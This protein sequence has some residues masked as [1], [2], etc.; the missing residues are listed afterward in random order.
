MYHLACDLSMRRRATSE[1]SSRWWA[2]QGEESG[3]G[4]LR[5]AEDR[6]GESWIPCRAPRALAF[7][8][9][10][11]A[12][13][14]FWRARQDGQSWQQER[15]RTAD[16]RRRACAS[17]LGALPGEWLVIDHGTSQAQLGRGQH[18]QPGPA[19]S[20]FGVTHARE[21]P[22]ERLLQEAEGVLPGEQIEAADVGAPRPIQVGDL[23]IAWA[24]PPEPARWWRAGLLGLSGKRLTSPSSRV[25]RTSGRRPRASRGAC[26]PCVFGCSPLHARTRSVPSCASS[27]VRSLSGGSHVRGAAQA[28]WC[29]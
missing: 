15:K 25:P 18:D 21:G 9:P 6:L 10:R 23:N 11:R 24:M 1:R 4:G 28:H 14:G 8:T 29:P 2:G 22:I 27:T 26:S 20:W 5:C 7:G 13:A 12:S 17:P 3:L 16:A 19:V